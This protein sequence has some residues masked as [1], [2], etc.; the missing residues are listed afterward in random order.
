MKKRAMTSTDASLKKIGGH[1]HEYD[2][3]EC[4][5]GEVNQGGQTDKKDVI[6][7]KHRIYSVKGGTWWQVFLYGRARFESNTAFK[8]LGNLSALMIECIDAFPA[9]WEQYKKNKMRAK[10][11][12]QRPMKLLCAELNK[13]NMLAAFFNKALFNGGEVSYL[14]ILPKEL[15][16]KQAS[17][18]IFH[19]FFHADVERVLSENIEVVNS[20]A[21]TRLQTDA[22]KVIFRLARNVGEIEIRTDSKLHHRQAKCRIN[23]PDILALLQK[24][25]GPGVEVRRQVI[26]YGAA[27]KSLRD[28]AG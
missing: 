13:P 14:S 6:D 26:A 21:R 15:G 25:L 27:T 8:G 22:Q 24:H 5:G 4:I 17:A 2:F 28:L 1:L 11:G 18:K 16:E 7:K 12:L 9:E 20:R 3:A 10:T 23:G 19:V